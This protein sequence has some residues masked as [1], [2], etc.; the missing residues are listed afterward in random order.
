[1]LVKDVLRSI[2]K[3]IEICRNDISLQGDRMKYKYKEKEKNEIEK[4][5]LQELK[6]GN[7]ST[8]NFEERTGIKMWKFTFYFSGLRKF[9]ESHGIKYTNCT[10][11]NRKDLICDIKRIYTTYGRCTKELYAKHGNFS[12]TAIRTQFGTFNKML[13]ELGLKINMHKKDDEETKDEIIE[14]V[15]SVYKKYGY[16]NAKLQREKTPYPQRTIENYFGSFNNLLAEC[17]IPVN[18][19]DYSDTEII[20][21][22]KRLH[23]E[24]GFVS[25][26]L[27]KKYGMCTPETCRNHFGSLD[28]VYSVAEI[29]D[30][31]NQRY[32]KSSNIVAKE[33]EKFGFSFE[34]EKTWSWLVNRKN[35]HH[36]YVDFFIKDLNLCIEYNGQ[37]HYEMIK[38]FHD[39]KE[40]FEHKKQLDELKEKLLNEHGLN[41]E[42]IRYSDDIKNKI[43]KILSL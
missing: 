5:V 22:I 30:T 18:K 10:V 26:E 16:L 23:N 25:N 17:N 11:I 36:L 19:R 40:V 42:V 2:W 8:L 4:R 41:L 29:E 9:C 12:I 35:N 37:Q 38:F 34:R 14:S 15:K 27:I 3:H 6:S 33:I 39:T 20:D 31:K 24:N 1:M 32:S 28:A 7:L 13:K 21:D 43:S